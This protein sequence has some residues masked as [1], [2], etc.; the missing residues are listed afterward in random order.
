M[1]CAITLGALW[2]RIDFDGA[3]RRVEQGVLDGIL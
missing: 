1:G 2:V 3:E